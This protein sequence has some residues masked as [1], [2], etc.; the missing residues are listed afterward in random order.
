MGI[1]T[2]PIPLGA[3]A[4]FGL[5]AA[6]L[7]NTMTFSAAFSAFANEIPWLIAIAFW[8]S[9]GFIK[10][11]LGNRIAYSIVSAFGKSTLGLTYSLVFAEALLSPGIPSLAARAGGITFPLAK[12]LCIACGSDPEKGTQDKLGSYIMKTCFQCTCVTSAM[13]ITAMAANPL[14]VNLANETIGKTISW[15]TWALGGIVP[16]IICLLTVPL[17]LY[18][19][20][21]PKVTHARRSASTLDGPPAPRWHLVLTGTVPSPCGDVRVRDRPCPRRVAR[22]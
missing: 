8:L 1:I 17:I 13:F 20:Y 3:V 5:G 16:G 18:V 15:G 11:G 4:I 7:T 21:P 6:V 2:K 22:R 12:A 14:A 9:M 19:L 10:S